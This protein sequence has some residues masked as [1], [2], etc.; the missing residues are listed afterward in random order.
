MRLTLAPD[1]QCL[2][3]LAGGITVSPATALAS[4]DHGVHLLP[5]SG[6][7]LDSH[8]FIGA[9]AHRIGQIL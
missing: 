3:Y 1:L 4:T 9:G 8:K 6:W 7:Y 5:L 2:T